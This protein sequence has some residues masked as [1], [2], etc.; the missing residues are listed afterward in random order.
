MNLLKTN[1]YDD[2]ES[3]NINR[4]RRQKKKLES[5]VGE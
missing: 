1:V 4:S 5:N 2:I 3:K